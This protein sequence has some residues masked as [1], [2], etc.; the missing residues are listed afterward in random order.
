[1]NDKSEKREPFVVIIG[2]EFDSRVQTIWGKLDRAGV[3]ASCYPYL[4]AARWELD[5]RFCGC[6]WPEEAQ[7]FLRDV[8][9]GMRHDEKRLSFEQL[10]GVVSANP[11]GAA[12]L[13]LHI[14]DA[15][16]LTEHGGSVFGSWLD[17]KGVALLAELDKENDRPD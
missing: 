4:T 2:E 1:M 6:G 13:V 7:G 12:L 11:K 15:M 8:L 16:R 5:L 3:L 9:R 14:L 17:T 10:M